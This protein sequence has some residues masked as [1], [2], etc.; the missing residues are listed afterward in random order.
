VTVQLF[1]VTST[2]ILYFTIICNVE[3]FAF[4]ALKLLVG[5]QEGHPA[6]KNL[7]GWVLVWLSVWS[8]VQTCIWP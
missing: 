3:L 4:S 1:R 5:W 2:M 7:I 8:L 6:C